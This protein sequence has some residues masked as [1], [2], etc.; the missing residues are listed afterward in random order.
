MAEDVSMADDDIWRT[1]YDQEKDALA[2]LEGY[3]PYGKIFDTLLVLQRDLLERMLKDHTCLNEW[4]EAKSK[5]Y[6]KEKD[7]E[8]VI[9][10]LAYQKTRGNDYYAMNGNNRTQMCKELTKLFGWDVDQN[11]LQ[12]HERRQLQKRRNKK[13]E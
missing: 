3:K 7:Y 12:Q 10:W 13:N 5:G 6:P 4:V 1:I 11:S 8:E 2:L 9:K